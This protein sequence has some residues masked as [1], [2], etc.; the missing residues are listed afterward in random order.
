[1]SQK[2]TD[3]PTDRL[4]SLDE[5]GD[6]LSIIPTEVRGFWH[7]RRNW[8]QFLLLWIFLALPW[9]K[10]NG[11][12]F[13]LLNL[14]ERKF[15]IFGLRFWADDA[16]ILFFILA[17]TGLTLALVTA[18]WGR[19]WCGWA[20]PQTVFIDQ[21]FRRIENW[22]EGSALERRQRQG[23]VATPKSVL[24]KII[25]WIVFAIISAIIGNNFLAYFV[26]TD[27]LIEMVTRPP[28][29]NWIS[30]LVMGFVTLV[31]CFDFGWFR[32]QFCTIMCPY[33]RFQ[34]VLMDSGSL[35]V[36]YD[37]VR[38]EPRRSAKAAAAGAN[39]GDCVDCG[40]C[41]AVCPTAIDIRRGVQMECIACTACID[42]CDEIMTKVK[43]PK[44]LIRYGSETELAG[45]SRQPLRG[46][47]VL[48]GAL[49]AFLS[50]GFA[51]ALSR[52]VPVE[53]LFFRNARE[54]FTKFVD[55][56]STENLLLNSFRVVV[57]NHRFEPVT[58]VIQPDQQMPGVRLVSPAT[59]I[60]AGSGG[61]ERMPIFVQFPASLTGLQ[62]RYDLPVK[63][64]VTVND[65]TEEREGTLQLLGPKMSH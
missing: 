36:V 20:C 8:V 63:I 26:G 34:S 56:D 47:V 65:K 35:A 3:L 1:V 44:G 31:T 4:G 61:I 11:M 18:V 55:K 37:S 52:R 19:V 10:L 9:I 59:S 14:P 38:G 21:V 62:G 39:A 6:R 51:F 41:V 12:P 43:K 17:G 7:R 23:S 64:M 46:R 32:E 25:K 29:E 49:L 24:R 48:Y 2:P 30:F 50:I 33:G 13:L 42:A 60:M 15:I 40:R 27:R 28:S 22:I 5:F 54:P 53:V 57:E 58:V 45:Q 16:P